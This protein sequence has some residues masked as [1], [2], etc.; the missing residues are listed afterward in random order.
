MGFGCGLE[1]VETTPVKQL[2]CYK[3]EQ[4]PEPQSHA[5]MLSVTTMIIR[6]I[7]HHDH[8]HVSLSE[9]RHSTSDGSHE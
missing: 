9:M 6:C 3:Q 4:N 5:V 1:R 7:N 2:G 8:M